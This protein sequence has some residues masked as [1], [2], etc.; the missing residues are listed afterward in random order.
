MGAGIDGWKTLRGIGRERSGCW[1]CGGREGER[2]GG[3]GE[4]DEYDSGAAA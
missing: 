1:Q 2:V 3:V 4:G